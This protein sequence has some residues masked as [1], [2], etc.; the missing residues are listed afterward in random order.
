MKCVHVNGVFADST[1]CYV[2]NRRWTATQNNVLVHRQQRQNDIPSD[3]GWPCCHLEPQLL[4][5]ELVNILYYTLCC[6]CGC[7][8]CCFVCWLLYNSGQCCNCSVLVLCVLWRKY[9]HQKWR[10]FFYV[11][12]VMAY[13]LIYLMWWQLYK[14]VAVISTLRM[15]PH[16]KYF[17][18][19]DCPCDISSVELRNSSYVV[20]TLKCVFILTVSVTSKY[21]RSHF[22]S[23]FERLNVKHCVH[24]WWE[25]YVILNR[26]SVKYM[27]FL[28]SSVLPVWYLLHTHFTCS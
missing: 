4:Q 1:I 9:D 28:C 14:M 26:V 15:F 3:E 2:Y 8:C 18:V 21:C 24:S 11:V 13:N 23:L 22:V 10:S 19:C 7:C 16:C 5:T 25:K 20:L 17:W 6:C 12:I 27:L